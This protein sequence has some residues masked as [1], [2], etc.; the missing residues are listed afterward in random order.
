MDSLAKLRLSS[1]AHWLPGR[2]AAV[3]HMSGSAGTGASTAIM[4]SG[5]GRQ[6]YPRSFPTHVYPGEKAEHLQVRCLWV[7]PELVC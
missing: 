2:M 3:H 6:G 1:Q 4:L 7:W 5:R